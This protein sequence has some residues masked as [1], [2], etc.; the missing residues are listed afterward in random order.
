[1]HADTVC[2]FLRYRPN[3]LLVLRHLRLGFRSNNLKVKPLLSQ[4]CAYTH[5]KKWYLKKLISNHPYLMALSPFSTTPGSCRVPPGAGLRVPPECPQLL[6]LPPG[7]PWLLL[8]SAVPH[9]FS[10]HRSVLKAWG[11][12]PP[13][14]IFPIPKK[15]KKKKTQKTHTG[16][17]GSF[18]MKFFSILPS[19][20]KS[21][22]FGVPSYLAAGEV[23]D[24]SILPDCRPLSTH[25]VLPSQLPGQPVWERELL[26]PEA[27]PHDRVECLFLL[28]P[29]TQTLPLCLLS[30]ILLCRSWLL[31]PV[32]PPSF[33]NSGTAHLYPW[34]TLLFNQQT[35]TLLLFDATSRAETWA[36][37]RGKAHSCLIC[38]CFGARVFKK[39]YPWNL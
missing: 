20:S 13:V 31:F 16:K 8:F 28:Q 17:L 37:E 32:L 24:F 30:H 10:C 12:F 11:S 35:C 18:K 22:G 39:S 23:W 5:A 25:S 4:V 26:K 14:P 38:I 21:S 6:V 9:L 36:R 29:Q 33:P 2:I 1:M 27:P 19:E 34:I 3:S 15:L 7:P